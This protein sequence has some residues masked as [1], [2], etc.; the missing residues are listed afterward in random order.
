MPSSFGTT[1]QKG[2]CNVAEAAALSRNQTHKGVASSPAMCILAP[3]S[4]W[5]RIFKGA[6]MGSHA[7]RLIRFVA[8]SL[9]VAA[10]AHAQYQFSILK[11]FDGPLA[12]IGSGV[13]IGSDG[14]L[15]AT[16][17]GGGLYG[18]GGIFRVEPDGTGFT[19]LHS[20]YFTE[21]FGQSALMQGADGSLYGTTDGAVF[22]MAKDG[23][24]FTILHTFVGTDGS[25]LLGALV[26]GPDGSLYG[27]TAGGGTSHDGTIF[28]IQ[29][30]GSGFAT[31]HNFVGTDGLGPRA[32]LSL[33]AGK[34]YGT[35]AQGG[36]FGSGTIFDLNP[37]GTSFVELHSF[38]S[39]DG[40]APASPLVLATDGA[41]YGTTATGGTFGFG[42]VFK[43]QTDGSG[44]AVLLSAGASVGSLG[45]GVIQGLDGALYGTGTSCCGGGTVY[46]VLTDG[47]N[48]QVLHAL[49]VSEGSHVVFPVTQAPDGTLYG[50]AQVG[51]STGS[52]ALFKLDPSGA[53]FTALYSLHDV[54]GEGSGLQGPVALGIDDRV[55]GVTSSGGSSGAGTVFS[56]NKHGTL[57]SVLQQMDQA[58][59]A[60]STGGL[61][62]GL[63]GA[64]YGTAMVG[65]SVGAGSVFKI[66]AHGQG[67][68][69]VSDFAGINGG[70]PAA[71][72]SQSPDGTLYG[73]FFFGGVF[74]M[75]PDGSGFTNFSVPDGLVTAGVTLGSDGMLYGATVPATS[76]TFGT[77][78]KMMPDGS[79][80]T[81][82]HAFSGSDGSSPNGV[83][84]GSD[85]ALYGT[86]QFG[87]N[88]GLGTI[89]KV[90]TDGSGFVT[91]RS[92]GYLDGYNPAA[93]LFQAG[94][95]TLLG[96]TVGG[97]PNG[98]GTVFAIR[99]DGTG[100][101][102]LHGFGLMDGW[103]PVAPVVVDSRGAIYGTTWYGG[104]RGGGVVFKLKPVS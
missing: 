23:S 46:R 56:V 20:Y 76:N 65:G 17:Y 90:A 34:L 57:F 70:T 86:T 16:S 84:F 92:L 94:D 35:T 73:T 62:R 24:G 38:G 14:A 9:F 8:A 48:L 99:S 26:Q 47:S 89:F 53:N 93:S 95:G 100:F 33:L 64:F 98:W 78:F 82:V 72:L 21:S 49:S 80:Q 6:E 52:G 54:S 7:T 63:D 36:A 97:G 37:D 74:K 40:A 61:I 11:D 43:I 41:L 29:P 59:G 104:P 51:G 81:V 25:L 42:T 83:I 13:L 45:P 4:L 12:G 88:L 18:E 2:S 69:V 67:F 71:G 5:N 66:R 91:L 19:L 55:F 39:S 10:S 96:T 44:F 32:A 58:Q 15:Y 102:I 22:K 31:I 68:K 85:G 27:T 3:P 60:L 87:G 103:N 75:Q 30:D 79:S 101:T 50:T 28:R 77:I 1:L